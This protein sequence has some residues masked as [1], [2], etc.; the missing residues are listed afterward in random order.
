MQLDF[1]ALD[2]PAKATSNPVSSGHSDTLEALVRNCA[3]R[4]SVRVRVGVI[5]E[6]D[7]EGFYRSAGGQYIM[8]QL[9]YGNPLASS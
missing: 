5:N 7:M 3:R 6:P 8:R 1:P 9:F 2:R 4:K